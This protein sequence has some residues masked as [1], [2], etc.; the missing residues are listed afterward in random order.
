MRKGFSLIEIMQTVILL[1][2]IAGLSVSFFKRIN[3]NERL[4]LATE[5]QLKI[6]I[7]EADRQ[8]CG[9]ERPTCRSANGLGNMYYKDEDSANIGS[10]PCSTIYSGTNYNSTTHYCEITLANAAD[11][12]PA[13]TTYSGLSHK[14]M[15]KDNTLC[16]VAPPCATSQTDRTGTTTYN[17]LTMAEALCPTNLPNYAVTVE[18]YNSLCYYLH[19][20]IAH[21]PQRTT[22]ADD[23]STTCTTATTAFN[24]M[25]ARNITVANITTAI[26]ASNDNYNMLLP[27]GVRLYNMG[28]TITP[29]GEVGGISA[30]N[31]FVKYDR[32]PNVATSVLNQTIKPFRVYNKLEKS[33]GKYI[34]R[35]RNADGNYKE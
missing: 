1:G 4:Y 23:L 26:N 21:K 11:S 3:S 19:K 29:K 5:K 9:D 17:A 33:G 30:T 2:I 34:P 27:N 22:E 24:E 18:G 20:I 6:A 31:I 8:M 13:A 28:A 32:V 10:L 35:T 7:T 25:N 15:S 14:E 12:C 16:Y